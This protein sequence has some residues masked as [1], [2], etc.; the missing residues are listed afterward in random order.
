MTAAPRTRPHSPERVTRRHTTGH[1]PSPE[2]P[3]PTETSAVTR[4]HALHRPT[5]ES[6]LAGDIKGGDSLLGDQFPQLKADFVLANPPFNV[7]EWG[8]AQAANDPRW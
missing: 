2:P 5:D 3:A 7:E 4:H 8:A 1:T 6:R